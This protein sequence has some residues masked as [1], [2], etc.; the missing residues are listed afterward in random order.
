[1]VL[2][3][4]DRFMRLKQK[5]KESEETERFLIFTPQNY[6]EMKTICI[7]LR[8]E[9][10]DNC[11]CI[12]CGLVTQSIKIFLLF[13]FSRKVM[14]SLVCVLTPITCMYRDKNSG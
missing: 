3:Y 9:Q 11:G 10:T 1:M 6:E 5:Y 12:Q 4:M 14:Q 8:K 7:N 13:F 2:E